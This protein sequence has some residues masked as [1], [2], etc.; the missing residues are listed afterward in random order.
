MATSAPGLKRD[1]NLGGLPLGGLPPF[2][3]PT[4][5]GDLGGGSPPTR[6]VWGAG[7]P[8]G[9]KNNIKYRP[10]NSDREISVDRDTATETQTLK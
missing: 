10:K 9:A 6:G 5:A 2:N 4:N 1:L 7:A 8:Q 3:P